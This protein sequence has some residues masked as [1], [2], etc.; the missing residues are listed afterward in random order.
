MI[1]ILTVLLCLSFFSQE[2]TDE[3][4]EIIHGVK[5]GGLQIK[6]PT[7]KDIFSHQEPIKNDKAMAIIQ[8]KEPIEN[9]KKDTLSSLS[10]ASNTHNFIFP[11]N[12]KDLRDSIGN[13]LKKGNLSLVRTNILP[14]S[15]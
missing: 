8:G 9:I 6:Y 3:E 2:Y 5:I 11:E 15:C 12:I 13:F 10:V 4:N 14:C 7:L 1:S